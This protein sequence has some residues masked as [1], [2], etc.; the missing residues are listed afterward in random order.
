MTSKVSEEH[1]VTGYSSTKSKV[2]GYPS[3]QFKS[4]KAQD[5]QNF[6]SC[7]V[8]TIRNKIH[9]CLCQHLQ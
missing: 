9:I 1:N 4:N 6:C 7:S 8:T 3:T 5:F 2:E